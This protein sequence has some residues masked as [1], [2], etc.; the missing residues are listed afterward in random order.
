MQDDIEEILIPEEQIIARVDALSAQITEA[1]QGRDLAVVAVL[2]GSCLFAS[3]LI[4]RIPIPLELA[5]VSASSYG[6]GTSP[7]EL[8]IQL[9]PRQEEI[10]DRDLL[11]VDDILD[12][13]RTLSRVRSELVERGARSVRTCV[14]LDKPARRA[15]PFEPDFRG[16]EIP[17]LFVVG[18]GLD[19]AGRYRNLP[20]VAS[21]KPELLAARAQLRGAAAPVGADSRAR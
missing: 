18:Y 20:F 21:L 7:G 4:R 14:L 1:Y 8:E 12:T 5:F 19:C 2:K 16:F 3:D 17:D 13:G 15:L 11:V 10:A 9:F 6:A